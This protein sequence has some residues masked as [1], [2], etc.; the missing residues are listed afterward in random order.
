MFDSSDFGMQ[1]FGV[2]RIRQ[3]IFQRSAITAKHEIP[4][5]AIDPRSNYEK[6]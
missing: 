5:L 2:I 4:I 3:Q 6:N 1:R